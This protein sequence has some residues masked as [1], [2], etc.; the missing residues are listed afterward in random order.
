[1]KVIR[2]IFDVISELKDKPR[3]GWVDHKIPSPETVW[4]HS[5]SMRS[6]SRELASRYLGQA[7]VTHC[8]KLGAVHDV[9]ES[10]VPDITPSM[11]I[12]PEQKRELEVIAINHIGT[13]S[14]GGKKIKALWFEF[15]DGATEAAR[16]VKKVDKL[17]VVY[18]ALKYEQTGI[19]PFSLQ[20]FWDYS[21]KHIEGTPL[22]EEW[23]HLFAQRPLKAND[24]PTLERRPQPPGT[25]D[26]M[27]RQVLCKIGA[28]PT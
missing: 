26:L 27:K 5:V 2:N 9:I 24:K 16:F 6:V 22:V 18:L 4:Q 20:P 12:S 1:M 28:N 7:Q 8:G 13:F 11:G 10:I 14:A 17:H 19:C 15:D 3:T 21:R 23:E 25:F